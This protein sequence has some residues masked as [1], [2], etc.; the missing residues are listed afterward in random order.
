MGMPKEAYEARMNELGKSYPLGRIGESEDIA[1]AILFLASND[2][3]FI[4]G[5]NLLADG[6]ALWTESPKRT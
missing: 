1:N 6:G 5:I 2:A 4:T 3:S